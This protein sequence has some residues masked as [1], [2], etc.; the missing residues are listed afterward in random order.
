MKKNKSGDGLCLHERPYKFHVPSQLQPT[1]D[2]F[3]V[4]VGVGSLV[5]MSVQLGKYLKDVYEAAA[6]FE[7]DIGSLFREMQD[8]DSVNKSIEQLHRT[9]AADYIFG[10]PELPRQD[11]EVWQNIANTLKKCSET[12]ADLRKVLEAIIGSSGVKVT[13]RRDGIKKHLRKQAKDGE[14]EKIRLKLSV[15]RE[16]LSVSLT[17][18]NLFVFALGIASHWTF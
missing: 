3:S 6:S 14:L 1:M 10:L 11:V 7:D 15:H 9:E 16:S 12:L 8:L 4:V 18:L 17:L 2:P 5:E 13:G